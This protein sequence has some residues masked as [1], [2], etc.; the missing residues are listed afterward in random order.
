MIRDTDLVIGDD[1]FEELCL[2]PV[3]G[4]SGMG[5]GLVPRDYSAHPVGSPDGA[6]EL[7]KVNDVPMIPMEEWPERIRE[8]EATKSCV[9]HFRDIGGDNG[10][11]IPSLNQ[12]QSNYCWAHSAT[13]LVMLNR[14]VAGMRYRRLSAF[15][16]ACKIKNYRNEGG[17]GAL[18][19]EYIVKHGVPDVEHWKESSWDR[20]NDT[21]YTW[22]NAKLY[23]VVEGFWDLEASVYDR[24]FSIQQQGSLMLQRVPIILDLNH[25]RHSVDGMDLVDAYPNRSARDPSRYGTRIWNSW[26]DVWGVRGTAV[27]KDGKNWADGSVA[28]RAAVVSNA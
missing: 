13:G 14:A 24:T 25:W 22:Q 10:G 3:V 12:L 4:T 16:I 7:R 6:I 17:W 8:L 28:A 19:M 2:G 5:R 1:N 20:S 18:A 11:P 27:L 15:A 9:S 21:D 23:Q 26:G